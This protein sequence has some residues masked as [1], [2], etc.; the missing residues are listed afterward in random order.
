MSLGTNI[1]RLR[2]E[3]HLSQGDL[4]EALDVSRQS[5]SKW[6]TDGSV[7]DLDKLVKLS[8][9][10]GVTLDEL[11]T[12]RV[13]GDLTKPA[14]P[15]TTRPRQ[16]V[17]TA[18]GLVFLLLWLLMEL[19]LLLRAPSFQTL[20]IGLRLYSS[21]LL[22]GLFCLFLR[23]R[24]AFWCGWILYL[25]FDHYWRLKSLFSWKLILRTI[26]FDPIENYTRLAI[27]WGL[28]AGMI[29]MLVWTLFTFRSAKIPLFFRKRHRLILCWLIYLAVSILILAIQ[30]IYSHYT[31]DPFYHIYVDWPLLAA[32]AAL[33]TVTACTIRTRITNAKGPVAK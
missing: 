24:T 3:K 7:P 32:F 28:F 2:T 10:F 20:W 29:V 26:H 21:L 13:P 16:P 31:F 5:V 11:V 14:V 4:A 17:R 6:E 1:S 9:V 15:A 33:L 18:L 19:S 30:G 8:R 25:G 22:C 23:R 12:G 27:A